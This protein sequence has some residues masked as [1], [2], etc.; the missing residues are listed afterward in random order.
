MITLNIVIYLYVFYPLP[1]FPPIKGLLFHK[2]HERSR[3]LS[4]QAWRWA[5][6]DWAN[7]A[8]ATTVMAGFFPIFFKTFW[9]NDLT[10]GERIHL[11]SVQQIL[12]LVLLI[13]LSAPI[14]GAFADAGNSKKAAS[15]VRSFRN[16]SNWLFIFRP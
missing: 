8:F 2:S 11:S 5:F 12:L 3:K 16:N 10:D 15:N 13:A 4:T 7:S 9:A 6:Y 1:F 14:L